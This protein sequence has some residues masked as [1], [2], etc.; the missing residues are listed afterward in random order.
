MGCWMRLSD[1]TNTTRVKTNHDFFLPK[2]IA[3]QNAIVYGTF[4]VT[5]ISEDDAKHY[6]EESKN[7]NVKTESISGPQK[8]MKW[9]QQE[10]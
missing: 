6:N 1:G 9:K 3:G 5:E 10:L 8:L 4:K 7:P 2:D